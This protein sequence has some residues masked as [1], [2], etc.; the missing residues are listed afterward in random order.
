MLLSGSLIFQCLHWKKPSSVTGGPFSTWP[1]SFCLKEAMSSLFKKRLSHTVLDLL[2]KTIW[3][4]SYKKE[5]IPF[6]D[7]FFCTRSQSRGLF[8]KTVQQ[9]GGVPCLQCPDS[10]PKSHTWAVD[11]SISISP[12]GNLQKIVDTLISAS[13]WQ[14][15]VVFPGVLLHFHFIP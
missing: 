2:T 11:V 4:N 13:F 12:P 15:S 14:S 3:K 1:Q 9:E 7:H 5:H 10:A 6:L 8:R